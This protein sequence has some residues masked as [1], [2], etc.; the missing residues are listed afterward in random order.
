MSYTL[1]LR[2]G[3]SVYVS[4]HPV[5]GIAHTRIIQAVGPRCRVRRHAV[6]ARLALWELL[7]DPTHE[8]RVVF[9]SNGAE[10][11]AR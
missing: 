5:T 4:C 8:T 3:C 10:L 7:P 6:G 9:V 11:V 2:C 1:S